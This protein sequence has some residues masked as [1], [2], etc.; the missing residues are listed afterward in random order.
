MRDGFNITAVSVKKGDENLL[1]RSND[2]RHYQCPTQQC[3]MWIGRL[4]PTDILKL[5]N[6]YIEVFGPQHEKLKSL[7][8]EITNEEIALTTKLRNLEATI[9]NSLTGKDFVNKGDEAA[10]SSYQNSISCLVGKLTIMNN[11]MDEADELRQKTFSM[12]HKVL[13]TRQ[14]VMTLFTIHDHLTRITTLSNM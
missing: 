9:S 7:T 8:T 3:I 13:N 2:L 5:I 1:S 4:R 14:K 12:M 11:F 6:N 10:L